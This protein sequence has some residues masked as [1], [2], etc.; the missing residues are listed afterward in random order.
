MTEK[1]KDLKSKGN[2][3]IGFSSKLPF[4]I[5]FIQ[6][7]VSWHSS[8]TFFV[9]VVTRNNFNTLLQTTHTFYSTNQ[10]VCSSH[11]T[12]D[13]A[14]T[15]YGILFLFNFLYVLYFFSSL[16]QIKINNK[17]TNKQAIKKS[18]LCC[19]VTLRCV[20]I[21]FIVKYQL[22]WTSVIRTII[23]KLCPI[24]LREEKLWRRSRRDRKNNNKYS[25][26]LSVCLIGSL[27][28]LVSYLHLAAFLKWKKKRERNTHA[29][30]NLVIISK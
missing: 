20:T 21:C 6:F 23:L 10:N 24:A 19:Y 16:F 26:Y 2:R 12:G 30:S 15:P 8:D 29:Q 13:F 9:Y 25:V 7:F 14:R 1:S 5:L 22:V 28:N 11:W 3:R 18:R 27:F 4:I 17:Q